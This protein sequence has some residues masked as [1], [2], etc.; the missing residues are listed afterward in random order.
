MPIVAGSYKTVAAKGI[1]TSISVFDP[2][3]GQVLSMIMNLE[4]GTVN[5][6][7]Q[8]MFNI[9]KGT[10]F[11]VDVNNNYLDQ[12]EVGSAFK[13]YFESALPDD[14]KVWALSQIDTSKN[15][16]LKP[17]IVKLSVR[18]RGEAAEIADGELI[19]CVSMEGDVAGY[20]L[21]EDFKYL[22]ELNSAVII[23]GQK[24]TTR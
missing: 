24:N 3:D 20:S 23:L 15:Q 10:E 13:A 17:A 18:K 11:S 7:N 12:V 22:T 1:V 8:V 6:K 16:Y 19:I 21:P 4:T 14:K 2:L 5:D 9:A